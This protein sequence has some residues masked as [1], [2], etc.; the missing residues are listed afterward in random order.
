MTDE[1]SLLA[2]S[3]LRDRWPNASL[4]RFVASQGIDWHVQ[5]GG[6]GPV[7][8][9]LHGTGAASFSWGDVIPHLLPHVTVV[10]PDLPGHAFTT[11]PNAGVLTL[12]GMADALGKLLATL[13]VSPVAVVGHS[14]GAAV[15]LRMSLDNLLPSATILG[16][17]PALVPPPAIYR[18]LLAPL[19]HRVA[20]LRPVASVAAWLAE[21]ADAP[22]SGLVASLL[23]ASN[24]QVPH[25]H[26]EL[27]Q[28]LFASPAH[29]HHV[30][31][32]M[33]GWSLPEL[34]R[35]LSRIRT[36]AVFIAGDRD[37]WVS[38]AALRAILQPIPG[39]ELRLERGGHLLHEERPEDAARWILA[40]A[41]ERQH[42]GTTA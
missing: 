29:D 35:D 42:D 32:M 23:R 20:A 36:P 28:A 26:L 5:V 4:S 41:T 16:F 19:V 21:R 17:N 40:S 30:L 33:A 25:R 14:A 12:G 13:G 10:V 27:Y 15:L 38:P 34:L 22:R 3:R 8:L 9:L 24:S 31:T 37:P 11:A 7:V 18:S 6:T 1:S 39:A 2:W